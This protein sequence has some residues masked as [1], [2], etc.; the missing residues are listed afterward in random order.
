MVNVKAVKGS[1]EPFAM[2]EVARAL[3]IMKNGKASKPTGIVKEHLDAF[4][5]GK[6]VILQIANEILDGKDMTHDW[7]TSKVV[8]IYRE[9]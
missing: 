5:H 2:K 1:M 7:R 8:S 6:Q 3:R 4:P 9:R